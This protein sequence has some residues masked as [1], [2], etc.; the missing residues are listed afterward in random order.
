MSKQAQCADG[1]SLRRTELDEPLLVL[2]T[3]KQS[4]WLSVLQRDFVRER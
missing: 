3:E 1:M 4:E 2:R